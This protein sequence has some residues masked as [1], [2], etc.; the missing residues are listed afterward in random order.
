LLNIPSA[1]SVNTNTTV[2]FSGMPQGTYYIHWYVESGV[3]YAHSLTVVNPPALY[4]GFGQ[5]IIYP[6]ADSTYILTDDTVYTCYNT[7]PHMI[8]TTPTILVSN[9]KYRWYDTQ[10]SDIILHEGAVY[11]PLPL[12]VSRSY[13]V[14]VYDSTGI[15]CE[16]DT[17]NRK[18]IIVIVYDSLKAGIIG[19]SHD[20]CITMHPSV[21]KELSQKTG[22]SDTIFYQWQMSLDSISW[23]NILGAN[24][25]D[26]SPNMLSV[27]TFFRRADMDNCNV[28]YT[29]PVKITV[30]DFPVLNDEIIGDKV[31]CESSFIQLS[32]ATIGGVWKA[33]N[34]NVSIPN[35]TANPVTITGAA[36]GKTYITYTLT[37]GE[38]QTSKTFLLKVIS[39]PAPEIKVGFEN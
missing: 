39:T 22:G 21:L 6:K 31:V 28:V 7:S 34:S 26:Y 20:I 23:T 9:P 10:T 37:N 5:Y 32:N 36:T 15:V 33:N 30:Y 27:T 17:N 14:S 12:T 35:P 29:N 16:N 19:T 11:I 24:T 3:V 8:V 13:F 2:S 25:T 1:D 4:G 38:C 18:E